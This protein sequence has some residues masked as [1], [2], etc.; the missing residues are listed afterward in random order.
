MKLEDILQSL[1]SKED[2][3][4]VAGLGSR[5]SSTA[6]TLSAFWI[7]GTGMLLGAGLALLFAPKPG[8]ALRHEIAE[9]VG[10]AHRQRQD[11]LTR[12]QPPESQPEEPYTHDGPSDAHP[13]RRPSQDRAE[14]L[15]E[16]DEEF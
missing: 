3:A 8:R 4:N 9:T 6:D 7:F 13:S 11:E 14:R 12:R 2:I 1:P 10:K 16:P 5:H 15:A